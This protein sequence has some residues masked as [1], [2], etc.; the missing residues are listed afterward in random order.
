MHSIRSC[1]KGKLT[2]MWHLLR[3]TFEKTGEQP[4]IKLGDPKPGLLSFIVSNTNNMCM[5][6]LQHSCH[7]RPSHSILAAWGISYKLTVRANPKTD[8]YKNSHSGRCTTDQRQCPASPNDH[9][10]GILS[11]YHGNLNFMF[12]TYP[13]SCTYRFICTHAYVFLLW[14]QL[15]GS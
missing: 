3:L 14:V 2:N 15:V 8:G 12:D 9:K 10:G 11:F 4:S 5:R 1:Q 7:S 6:N 13:A